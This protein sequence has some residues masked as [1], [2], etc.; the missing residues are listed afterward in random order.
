MIIRT[1]ELQDFEND[2]IRLE[3]ADLLKNLEIVEAMYELAV[4]LGAFPLK[5]PL[6][7]IENKIWLAKVINSV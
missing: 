6:E 5:N 4:T 1:E 2:Q 7:G 3:K